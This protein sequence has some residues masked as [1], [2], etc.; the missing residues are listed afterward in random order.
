LNTSVSCPIAISATHTIYNF[1][2]TLPTLFL[3][4]G[5]PM[6]ALA[7]CATT[8]FWRDLGAQLPRPRAILAV[9]AHW[10]TTAPAAS[11]STQPDTIH[12]FY[13]FPEPLYQLQYAAPSAPDVARRAAQL[14]DTAGLGPTAL[15]ERGLDHG[16]W[17]P[18]RFM[19]PSHDIPV[20]Q[21]AVQ[22][23]LG[24]G[25]HYAIGRALAPLA[26]EGVLILGSGGVSHNLRE[27]GSVPAG[28]PPPAWMSEF[29]MWVRNALASGDHE[30]L[31]DYVKRAPH[32]SRNHPTD[33]HFLPLFVALGAARANA[34]VTRELSGEAD[35][36][37]ALDGYVFERVAQTL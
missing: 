2:N 36:A 27:W 25:H 10:D 4:H 9:S 14:I 6:M 31:I 19:Y 8:Q 11:I 23:R 12:D 5:S 24:A 21:L 17:A 37:I 35:R 13:G 29:V 34:R 30:A 3:S 32:A 22:S 28:G 15:N 7:E 33:E 1:M 16:A 20:T 18:L 26:N